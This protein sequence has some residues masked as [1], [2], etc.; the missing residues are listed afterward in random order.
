MEV[1]LIVLVAVLLV[2]QAEVMLEPGAKRSRQVPQFIDDAPIDR[3]LYRGVQG[4]R[5]TTAEAHIGDGWN[6]RIRLFSLVTQLMPA[7]TLE[8]VPLPLQLS[9]RTAIKLTPLATPYVLPPTVPA[10]CVP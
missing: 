3:I 2:Y 8:V 1:P 7:T 6:A 9:T 5:C 10:T 4:A